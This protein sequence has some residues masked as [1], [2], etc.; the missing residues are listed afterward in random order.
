[1]VWFGC[2]LLVVGSGLCVCEFVSLRVC[3]FA[4]LGVGCWLSVVG[5]LLAVCWLFVGCLLAVCWLFV[6]C[7]LLDAGCWLLVV[8]CW[9]LVVGCWLLAVG[10]LLVVGCWLLAVGCWF[11]WLCYETLPL[12]VTMLLRCRDW[13]SRFG[14]FCYE[15]FDV[16]GLF[17]DC[18]LIGPVLNT[19]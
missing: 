2:W 10:W 4:S 13:G 6:G 11:L 8:G 1:M 15:M 5:C 19:A 12:Y 17:G 3:E 9:W 16:G 14:E 7:L 18:V